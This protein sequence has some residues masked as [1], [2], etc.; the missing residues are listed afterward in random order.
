MTT[1]KE[2]QKQLKYICEVT[3]KLQTDNDDGEAPE[4]IWLV[5]VNESEKCTGTKKEKHVWKNIE[6]FHCSSPK[7]VN[8]E[9][10]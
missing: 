10:S 8:E 2:F 7:I 9:S 1:Q 3:N 4:K 5:L 6:Y